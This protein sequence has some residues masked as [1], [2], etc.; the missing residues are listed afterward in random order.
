MLDPVKNE[1]IGCYR[2]A[3]Q[4]QFW[5]TMSAEEKGGVL[6]QCQEKEREREEKRRDEIRYYQATNLSLASKGTSRSKQ[7]SDDW[8][9]KV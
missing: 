4:I 5:N 6:Y 2:T 9:R 7:S 3:Y 1:C 8:S